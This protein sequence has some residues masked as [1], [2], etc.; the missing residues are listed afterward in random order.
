M[1]LTT[2]NRQYR[3]VWRHEIS[4]AERDALSTK[5]SR[6]AARG[7]ERPN[8]FPVRYIYFGTALEGDIAGVSGNRDKYS[9]RRDGEA[10][11]YRLEKKSGFH[12]LVSRQTTPLTQDQCQ[13]LLG[14]NIGWMPATEDVLLRELYAKMHQGLRPY[15]MTSMERA[16]YSYE[17]G[18]VQVALDTGVRTEFSTAGFFDAPQPTEDACFLT[19]EYNAYLPEA[20]RDLID[21]GDGGSRM[22]L[23]LAGQAV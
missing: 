18:S 13:K 5:L 17:P 15:K 21:I 6:A 4:R 19:V 22:P 16:L 20:I 9:L 1:N 3:Q 8:P 14:G 12:M 10:G 2:E 11:V 23:R 7:A